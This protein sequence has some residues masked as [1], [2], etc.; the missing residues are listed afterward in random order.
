MSG[1]R[2]FGTFALTGFILWCLIGLLVLSWKC[3]RKWQ[4]HRLSLGG[5]TFDDNNCSNLQVCL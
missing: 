4:A 3:V 1:W 5:G 2:I